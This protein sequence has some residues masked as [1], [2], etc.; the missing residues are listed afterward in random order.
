[1]G[2]RCRDAGSSSTRPED[3]P[4]AL[5][6]IAIVLGVAPDLEAA[7]YFTVVVLFLVQAAW[8]LL[9]LVFMERRPATA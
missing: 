4:P 7:L 6:L 1:V 8:T 9:W 3:P 5:A 2:V